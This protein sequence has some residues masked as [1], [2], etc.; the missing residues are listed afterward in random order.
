M[1]IGYYK[2]INIQQPTKEA[3]PAPVLD[4]KPEAVPLPDKEEK[5]AEA[6]AAPAPADESAPEPEGVAS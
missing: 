6:E 5:A 4:N 2:P 1:A 3:A